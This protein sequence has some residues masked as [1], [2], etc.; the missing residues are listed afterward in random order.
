MKPIQ[1]PNVLDAKTPSTPADCWP[2]LKTF[3]LRHLETTLSSELLYHSLAHT[4][5]DVLPAAERLAALAQLDA[6][7][8]LI[9]RVA[10]LFHDA[11]FAVAYREN[12]EYAAELARKS[13]PDFGFSAA[14]I[15]EIVRLI[16][17]TAMPQQPES[18][19]EALLCDADLD[20]LGRE[21][22][23]ETSLNL[24]R[25][26]TLQGQCI[27]L[28]DW[29]RDQVEFLKAHRYFTQEA[30]ALRDAGKAANI[31]LLEQLLETKPT[32]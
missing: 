17:A 15:E 26:L 22:Y 27:S 16:M 13:L 23:L 31:Q 6:E 19:L 4:R 28:A 11:G 12:E 25:E 8:K 29:Y 3:V 18:R 30:K 2:E 14:Q 24:W 32:S 1:E 7:K 9:L 5:D 10:A 21:D 20:S